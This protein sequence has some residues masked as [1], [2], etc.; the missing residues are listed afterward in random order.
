MGRDVPLEKFVEK[1][2]EVKADIV[3]SSA[4]MTTTML[5]QKQLEQM[6]KDAGIRTKVKTIVGGAPITEAWDKKIGANSYAE[7]A[8]EAV[9]R[10][11]ELMKG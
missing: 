3:G 1:A 10:I 7:N 11:Q 5:A 9:K 4:L 8:G 6:L 2:K